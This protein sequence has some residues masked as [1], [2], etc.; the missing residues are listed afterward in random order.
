MLVGDIDVN[1]G[2]MEV[3]VGKTGLVGGDI[4]VLPVAGKIDVDV[5]NIGMSGNPMEMTVG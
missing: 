4:H 1:V 5:G 2:K 3:A